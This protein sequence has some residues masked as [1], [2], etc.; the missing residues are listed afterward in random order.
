[1]NKEAL[2]KLKREVEEAAKNLLGDKL[3]KV[4]LYGSY[5]RGDYNLE[6]DIDFVLM[7]ELTES[8]IPLYNDKLGEIL[9][10]LSINYGI[11]VTIIIISSDSFNKYK[12]VMP[13]YMNLVKEGEVFYG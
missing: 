7:S 5:A 1:M 9:S 12:D 2:E 3:I 8:E 13:F 10:R 4:I 6:S 11:L